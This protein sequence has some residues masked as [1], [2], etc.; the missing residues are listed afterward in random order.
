MKKGFRTFQPN[1]NA[2]DTKLYF[3]TP[4]PFLEVWRTNIAA[5]QQE[6]ANLSIKERAAFLQDL[7]TELFAAKDAIEPLYCQ[8]SGL[9]K[10]RFEAEFERTFHTVRVFADYLEKA[11]WEKAETLEQEKI[12]LIKR[13]IPIGPVLV[14]GSSNFPLAYSTLGGD[15][16]AAFAAGCCVV[17]KAHPMHVGTSSLVATCIS[18]A[19]D[20]RQLSPDIFCH[21]LD[22]SYYWASTFAK[23]PAIKAIGFTGSIKGGRALM[24]IAAQRPDPIPVFAEMGSLNP[25][26]ISENL[27]AAALTQAAEKLALSIYTDAGQ[28]CTKPGLILVHEQQL[29]SFLDQLRTALE[30]QRPVPMLHPDIFAKYE[31]RKRQVFQVKSMKRHESLAPIQGIEARWALAETTL[32]N[33]SAAEAAHEEV[34]GPF[35]VICS[36]QELSACTALLQKLGGQLTATVFAADPTAID[37][38]LLFQ[39]QTQVGRLIFNGV[40]TG[41]RVL[42]T[43]HHGGPYPASSDARFSAVGP[44]SIKRFTKEVC[45]QQHF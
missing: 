8:E 32:Q 17:L 41:V 3:P 39:L 40:P 15:T 34:F 2:W 24:D 21:V 16:V 11:R 13:N 20:K 1:A 45:F 38:A 35:A 30:L 37:P 6:F 42:E 5:A 9:S 33:L 14:L 25:V 31:A 4:L 43:M 7:A 23:D 18:K 29:A 22:D 36:Y 10:K 12:K 44:D 26:I 28:F 19:L 27:N